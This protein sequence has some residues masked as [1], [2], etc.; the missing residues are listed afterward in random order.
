VNAEPSWIAGVIWFSLV[1]I[2]LI[3]AV[4][5]W[6]RTA[7]R[8]ILWRGIGTAIV[9]AVVAL[10][11]FGS[12]KRQYNREHAHA[13]TPVASLHPSV[14]REVPAPRSPRRPPRNT[15]ARPAPQGP[16]TAYG[17][18]QVAAGGTGYQAN[19]PNAKIDVNPPTR[20]I[21]S[22]QSQQETGN[23][24]MPW[25]AAF[26]ISVTGAISTG[27]VILKCDGDALKIAISRINTSYF[28]SG[29]NG[30]TN[31]PTVIKYELSPET[32]EPGREVQVYVY[33][34]SPVKVLAG[35]IGGHPITF[36]SAES[37]GI[38]PHP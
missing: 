33:S 30:P 20:V 35:T 27:D 15:M 5:L 12:I 18:Q 3:A 6:D 24:A 38:E 4:W 36:S 2:L 22:V 34:K 29:S 37:G 26:T 14:P 32:L 17:V 28:A 25:R 7:D 1:V 31:D 23:P 13:E 21:A 16:V 19:G 11:S 9:I 8:H 10:G